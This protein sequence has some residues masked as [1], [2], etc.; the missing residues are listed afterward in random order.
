MAG[1]FGSQDK[2]SIVL[3][4]DNGIASLKDDVKEGEKDIETLWF[5]YRKLH[6]VLYGQGKHLLSM[7]NKVRFEKRLTTVKKMLEKL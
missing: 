1:Y 2:K 5:N 3:L 4:L 6:E 7:T